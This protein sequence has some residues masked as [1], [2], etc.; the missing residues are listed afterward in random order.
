MGQAMGALPA[1]M[2][3]ITNMVSKEL[4]AMTGALGDLLAKPGAIN[5]MAVAANDYAKAVIGSVAS[6]ALKGALKM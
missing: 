3:N 4:S 5:M 2:G 6:G 1:V